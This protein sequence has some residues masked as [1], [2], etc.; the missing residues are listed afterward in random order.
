[1]TPHSQVGSGS[2]DRLLK[3]YTLFYVFQDWSLAR[4]DDPILAVSLASSAK[5]E[6]TGGLTARGQ[7]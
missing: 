6:M 1:M 5:T 3:F 2:G 7:V 4:R